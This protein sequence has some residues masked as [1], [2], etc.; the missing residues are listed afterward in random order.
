MVQTQ[1]FLPQSGH[2][3]AILSK[4]NAIT[5]FKAF[6]SPDKRAKLKNDWPSPL[7]KAITKASSN[8]CEVLATQMRD[9]SS[10]SFMI[11]NLYKDLTNELNEITSSL[12]NL[13]PLDKHFN[14]KNR[15]MISSSI[16]AQAQKL[17]YVLAKC[18]SN[19]N[20]LQAPWLEGH[21]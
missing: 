2:P 7:V 10:S 3:D 18:Y 6:W 9:K 15:Y 12:W 11:A 16:Y 1:I 19:A 13:C 4:L 5:S 17:L 21:P 14:L 20:L 8:A